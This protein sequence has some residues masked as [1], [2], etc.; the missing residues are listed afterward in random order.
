MSWLQHTRF[1][2][3]CAAALGALLYVFIL[4]A[5]PYQNI[6]L[7]GSLERAPVSTNQ[8]FAYPAIARN[9]SFNGLVIGTS[10]SRLLDPQR[11]NPQS[12][13]RFA[14]LSMNSAT[15]YEQQQIHA[16]FVK[17]HPDMRYLVIGVDE[18]WCNRSE[19]I[20]R[21]TFRRF[22]PWLFD[23]NRFNDFLY[24]FNGKALENAVR[25]TE[26]LLG[27][28]APKYRNDGY[29]DFTQDFGEW[30][31][32]AVIPRLYPKGRGPV[33]AASVPPLTER[34]DWHFPLM[35][36]LA[37]IV[38]QTPAGAQIALLLPPLHAQHIS[39]RA[40]AL[41]ECKGRVVKL[42][43]ADSRV[44]LMDYMYVSAL[45][46]E[47]THYWDAVHFNRA[48]ARVLEDDLSAVFS[49]ETAVSDYL[50]RYAE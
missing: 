43:A 20:E 3:F 9:P 22:P 30:R 35:N 36:N 2:L 13:A 19:N 4:V 42:A 28:R 8:R 48:V 24:L 7:V 32:Q 26:L 10:T 41:S 23:D 45:N 14:N 49:G 33:A 1:V 46:R 21:F 37:D 18:T 6:S 40:T 38:K 29:R 31:A 50:R 39:Q 15:A 12:S 27:K 47:D 44:T 16:L 11:I 25:M 5:D 17:H 34:G